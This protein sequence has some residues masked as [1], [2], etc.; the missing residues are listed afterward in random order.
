MIWRWF[1][2]IVSALCLAG[3]REVVG[4]DHLSFDFI[5]SSAS[6]HG[7]ALILAPWYRRGNLPV[8]N[9]YLHDFERSQTWE[10]TDQRIQTS[11]LVQ[12]LPESN[13]FILSD[14]FTGKFFYLDAEGSLVKTERLASYEGFEESY[15]LKQVFPFADGLYLGTFAD[16]SRAGRFRLAILNPDT[17]VL[18]ILHEEKIN[19]S[20]RCYWI[21]GKGK[22]FFVVPETGQIDL[23]DMETFKRLETVRREEEVV[24]RKGRDLPLFTVPIISD[25]YIYLQK[26][27]FYDE[28]GNPLAKPLK[29]VTSLSRDEGAILE[30]LQEIVVGY[31]GDRELIYDLSQGAFRHSSRD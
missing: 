12:V 6:A 25:R 23:L 24:R 8:M 11:V 31:S 5:S 10:L 28:G 22:I 4:L 18:T 26:N 17:T 2:L 20:Q 15:Q 19:A 30:N 7:K 9:L 21:P 29:S 1:F 13:G 16:T 27:N 3:E 14:N